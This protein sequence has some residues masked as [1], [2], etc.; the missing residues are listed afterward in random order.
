MKNIIAIIL[1]TLAL[2]FVGNTSAQPSMNILIQ[3]DNYYS[4]ASWELTDTT[5]NIIYS[6]APTSQYEFLNNTIQITPGNYNITLYDSY[7]DGWISNFPSW[8]LFTDICGDTLFYLQTNFSFSQYDTT[9]NLLPCPPPPVL[10]CNNATIIINTDQYPEETEWFIS[11]TLGTVMFSGGPYTNVPNYEPQIIDLCLPLMPLEFTITDAYGDGLGGALWGGIDGSWYIVQ[12]GDT[13]GGGVGNFG[14]YDSLSFAS[15]TC[16][17]PPPISGCMDSLYLEYNP[18]AAVSD[19]SCATLAVYG[20]TDSTMWNYNDTANVD[21][22]VTS[23]NYTLSLT[24]LAANGWAGSYVILE[25]NDSTYGPFTIPY[26]QSSID[27]N[28]ALNAPKPVRLKFFTTPQSAFTAIEC[29]F[30]LYSSTGDTTLYNPGGFISNIQPYIWYTGITNC[31]NSCLPYVYGCTD[32]LALNYDSLANTEDS[33]CYYLPGCTSPAYLEYYT[34]G[35]VA[36]YDNGSCDTLAVWG[37]MDSTA[38]NY[39]STANI[40]NGG[41]LPIISGCM[42]PFAFNYDPLANTPDTCLPFVYGCTDASMFNYNDSANTDDGSCIPIKFG[43]TDSTALNFNPLANTDNG[44]CEL[45]VLGCTDFY[46]YNYNIQ[47]NIDDSSC[48]YDA[49]C[50]TG[51]GNPYWLNDQCYAWVIQVDPYC[52]E[53]EWDNI[54]Q[55]TYDYCYDGWT[56]NLPPARLEGEQIIVYPNP[57]NDKIYVNENVNLNVFN[58]LGDIIVSGRNINVLDVSEIN[59]GMYI[60]HIIYNDKT[61]IKNIIIK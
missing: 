10:A 61:Y 22:Y 55:L 54:C 50:T 34:Q 27:T 57:A 17:P 49:G 45:P 40:D 14:Y 16:I 41:C 1:F 35:F 51:P 13:L 12:C 36:D 43:C 18:L 38:F 7:G 60:I 52:C 31:G 44:T 11:D 48:V 6:H 30:G 47:A 21:V 5:G 19:S 37:C 29:G 39:D 4:E 8:M 24:D 59:P 56:G 46:A 28:I 42:N 20:C 33:T 58:T 53:T 2:L 25:H 3:Y 23:C 15:D 32:T 26:G 9:V